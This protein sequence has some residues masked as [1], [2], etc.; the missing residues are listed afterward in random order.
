MKTTKEPRDDILR[1][2][3][4]LE[5]VEKS[6]GI[7]GSLEEKY[8]FL[9][10]KVME[11]DKDNKKSNS[12]LKL[13]EKRYEALLREKDILQ[14]E[15]NKNV[16]MRT[17]LEQVCREQQKLLKSVQNESMKHKETQAK[18]QHSI[19]EISL[20]L[21][22]NNEENIKLKEDNIEMTKK[23]KYLAEQ[24]Q[25][26]EKQLEKIN[27]QVQLENQLHEAKLAKVQMEATM[28]KEILLREKQ[29][30]LD[31][32]LKSKKS[33][34]EMQK[35]EELLKEQLSLY[36]SKYDDFQ[37]SLQKSNDIFTTYKAELEK[38]VKKTKKLEK[39][40]TEWKR[41]CEKSTASLLDLATEKQVKDEYIAKT[42]RQMQQLQ[43]LLRTLQA[44]RTTLHKTLKD[45]NIDIPPMPV[46]PPEPEPVPQLP[47]TKQQPDKIETMAK[48]CAEL[49]QS[50]ALLQDQ[51]SALTTKQ[52][53]ASE[54]EVSE[55]SSRSKNKKS[56][57]R[58][59]A[60]PV[61]DRNLGNT[62]LKGKKVRNDEDRI[63]KSETE[64]GT[65]DQSADSE[66][67]SVDSVPINPDTTE[68]PDA[69]EEL[70]DA[71]NELQE[72]DDKSIPPLQDGSSISI[73][74]NC[75]TVPTSPLTANT[76]EP[77]PEELK[78]EDN[79]VQVNEVNSPKDVQNSSLVDE[80]KNI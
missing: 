52:A 53:P 1:D 51:M 76:E 24:Y 46:L 56:K 60:C 18:F 8:Q 2:S 31:D 22:K 75:T 47:Q 77:L 43:K 63:S 57:A 72:S 33:L 78:S 73:T 69:S 36:T 29:G 13:H 5:Q 19:N 4:L 70:K 41:K 30:A 71:D 61:K 17:K 45:N 14:K 26:R 80:N 32:L 23:L 40:S 68:S 62:E 7:T 12:A 67:K 55:T 58:N 64:N 65:R 59:K 9:I 16:L 39:E 10:K 54:Q 44:E 25:I 15:H 42:N 38:M 48:S 11:L 20:T 3:K 34:Q 50:L 66:V 37:N 74:E 6:F 21:N 27:E 49:K 79:A 35:R 28:E